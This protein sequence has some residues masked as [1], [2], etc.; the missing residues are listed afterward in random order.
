MCCRDPKVELLFSGALHNV[1]WQ[2]LI[3]VAEQLVGSI[4]KRIEVKEWSWLSRN[5]DS[6]L[7]LYSA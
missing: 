4:F 7:P 5:V 2:F 6:E 3:D 1:E